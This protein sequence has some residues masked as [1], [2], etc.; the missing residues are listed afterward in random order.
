MCCAAL[1]RGT[2]LRS[3]WLP[4]GIVVGASTVILTIVG[5]IF[6]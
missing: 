3:Y 1:A 2:L 4:F 6:G 5:T